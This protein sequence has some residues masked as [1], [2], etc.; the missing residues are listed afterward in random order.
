MAEDVLAGAFAA[1]TPSATPRRQDHTHP[2]PP[3]ASPPFR[4]VEI[5]GELF[6]TSKSMTDVILLAAAAGITIHDLDDP[7]A[8]RWVGGGKFTWKLH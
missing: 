5:D 3:G 4:V 2:E 1:S 7:D 6:G 8:V